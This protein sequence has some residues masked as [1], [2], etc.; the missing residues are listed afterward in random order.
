MSLLSKL[1]G[2]GPKAEP[3]VKPEEFQ[4]FT[5][6]PSP[7]RVGTNWRIG[8]VIEKDGKSHHL[9]R[10]DQ[11]SAREDCDRASIAKAKQ[12]IQE[13]GDRLFG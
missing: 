9:I 1:F 10:A 13:Q 7:E 6:T 3:E 11:L 2:S 12:M 8:A 4:G 5:I